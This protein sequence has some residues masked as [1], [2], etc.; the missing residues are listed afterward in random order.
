MNIQA[1]LSS[2]RR[3][4]DDASENERL[5]LMNFATQLRTLESIDE[6]YEAMPCH[7]VQRDSLWYLFAGRARGAHLAAVRLL[8]GGHVAEVYPLMRVALEDAVYAHRTKDK[9]TARIWLKRGESDECRRTARKA[10]QFRPSLEGLKNEDSVIADAVSQFYELT[11]DFGAHP[12]ADGHLT[13][14]SFGESVCSMGILMPGTTPWLVCFQRLVR[15]AALCLA[16]F[17]IVEPRG[18]SERASKEL[19]RLLKRTSN[20]QEFRHPDGWPGSR[21]S[22]HAER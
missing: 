20:W 18:F 13:T 5:T 4:L 11:I 12:N 9:Q 2:F 1:E 22:G 19:E 16:V 7:P 8:L 17:R 14:A 21:L 10:L 6:V 15:C 3:H